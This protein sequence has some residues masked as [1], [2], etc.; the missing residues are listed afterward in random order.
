MALRQS[1]WDRMVFTTL[2]KKRYSRIY[3]SGSA[4]FFRIPASCLP[5]SADDSQLEQVFPVCV[6]HLDVGPVL[7]QKPDHPVVSVLS[8]QMER[9]RVAPVQ[10]VDRGVILPNKNEW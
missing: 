4:A 5:V 6:L 10:G 2:L 7:Q 8:R 1:L 3:I 9:G